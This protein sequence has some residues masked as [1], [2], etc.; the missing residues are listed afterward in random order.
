MP[1]R[2]AFG[3]VLLVVSLAVCVS[4]TLSHANGRRQ[5]AL[6]TFDRPTWVDGVPLMGTYVI[7]HDDDRMVRGGRCTALYRLSGG[8][9][10]G[11]QVVS[12]HCIPL[13]RTAPR[14]FAMRT[15][16]DLRSGMDVLT[17]YQFAGDVEA[18][19]VPVVTSIGNSQG[20]PCEPHSITAVLWH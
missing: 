20:Y 5:T 14:R 10:P 3:R 15:E 16:K 4:T 11:D 9:H 2:I 17:E 1:K 6:I 12:F 7:E 13:Q 8:Q 19:G 18:H